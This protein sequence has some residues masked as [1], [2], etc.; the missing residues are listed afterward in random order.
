MVKMPEDRDIWSA[1]YPQK[2]PTKNLNN[3]AQQKPNQRYIHRLII[4][5]YAKI[6]GHSGLKNIHSSTHV[7]RKMSEAAGLW[8]KI[9]AGK[10]AGNCALPASVL[11]I[12]SVNNMLPSP[13]S[14]NDYELN[15]QL[16]SPGGHSNV[17]LIHN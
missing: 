4:T 7:L 3:S 1:R 16:I 13:P 10:G 2:L 15:N 14:L 11:Q 9:R 17:V 6:G 5:I 8:R 12:A